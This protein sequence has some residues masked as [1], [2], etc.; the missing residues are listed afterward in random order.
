MLFMMLFTARYAASMIRASQDAA[1]AMMPL[2]RYAMLRFRRELDAA[3]YMPAAAYFL[4]PPLFRTG[5]PL[6]APLLMPSC[7]YFDATW[8]AAAAAYCQLI[9]TP[10]RAMAPHDAA[11]FDAASHTRPCRAMQQQLPVTPYALCHAY[12]CCLPHAMLPFFFQMP[13]CRCY[14]A[15][16]ITLRGAFFTAAALSAMLYHNIP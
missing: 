16:T 1:A 15:A 10:R 7:Y 5:T 8:R 3:A 2:F 14:G 4:S 11:F 9:I 13:R 6:Y 12:I